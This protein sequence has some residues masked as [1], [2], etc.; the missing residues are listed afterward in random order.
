MQTLVLQSHLPWLLLIA[1]RCLVINSLINSHHLPWLLLTTLGHM[2]LNSLINSHHLLRLLLTALGCMALNSPINSHCLPWLLL[3]PL[4][5]YPPT[6][7]HGPQFSNQLPPH[8]LLIGNMSW[9]SSIH[10]PTW[11]YLSTPIN[12]HSNSLSG[13]NCQ[14]HAE[15]KC[16]SLLSLCSI[17]SCAQIKCHSHLSFW[18]IYNAY[19]NY[20]L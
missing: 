8:P 17:Q 19:K 12:T 1:L 4:N 14:A 5:H 10:T 9:H 13:V 7:A 20:H 2:A 18:C 16:H 3:T 6:Q 15:I 11:R